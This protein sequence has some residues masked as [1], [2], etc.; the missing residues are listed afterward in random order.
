MV[1]QERN[2]VC[3]TKRNDAS[4]CSACIENANLA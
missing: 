3:L 2:K 4:D 1:A